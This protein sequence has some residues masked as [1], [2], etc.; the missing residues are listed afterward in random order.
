M[1]DNV[2]IPDFLPERYF[3]QP[4]A[5]YG[6]F[7]DRFGTIRRQFE[8]A[9]QGTATDDGFILDEAFIYDDG[10]REKR[11]WV[12]VKRS[13]GHYEGRCDDVIGHATGRHQDNVLR[14]QYRFRLAMYGR[15]V[16][17]HFDDVM[18]L[19]QGGVMVNRA[20]ISKWGVKLGEVLLSFRPS[21]Q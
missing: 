19:H 10:V 3:V 13:D 1:A 14:W 16:S 2:Q 15:K 20:T 9:I 12:I 5:A 4:L 6:V 18:V 8:V 11:K 7:V 21:G 17:V